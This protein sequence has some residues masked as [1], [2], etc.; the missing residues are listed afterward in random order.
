M[1]L[2]NLKSG[3][4]AIITKIDNSIYGYERLNEL[5]LLVGTKIKVVRYSPF[6]DPLII[7]V[8]GV[9]ICIRVEVARK[10]GVKL[11]EENLFDRQS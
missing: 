5:G 6:M 10:I 7:N 9:D 4:T 3:E 2:N 8:R 11:F 1:N